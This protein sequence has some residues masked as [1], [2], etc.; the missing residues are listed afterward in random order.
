MTKK[1]AGTTIAY[2]VDADV[3]FRTEVYMSD[4]PSD[5]VELDLIDL[6][7]PRPQAQRHR[8]K[9]GAVARALPDDEPILLR[10]DQIKQTAVDARAQPDTS[11]PPRGRRETRVTAPEDA[12]EQ[13]CW[14]RF[15]A[16]VVDDGEL[17]RL[18]GHVRQVTGQQ[19]GPV[20]V[21]MRVSKDP[22]E[23]RRR[24]LD[25]LPCVRDDELR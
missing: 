16:E 13:Q 3:Y 17:L 7:E 11:P 4:D 9:P 15:E 6:S 8:D 14:L 10:P 18:P 12:Q 25:G 22:D 24:T 19:S 2:D 20:E 21:H 5:T 23:P 1:W